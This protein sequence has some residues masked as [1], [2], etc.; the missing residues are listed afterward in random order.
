MT[1]SVDLLDRQIV[2]LVEHG[3]A[4][5]ERHVPVE[6]A[7]LLVAGRQD[8]VLRRN[9]VD[10]VL[11]RDA[12]RL[13]RLLIEIDLHLQ[14]LAAIGRRHRGAL[15]GGELRP[16]EVLSEVEQLHLRQ[17]AARQRELEDRHAGGVVAQDIGR[18]DAGRQQFQHGLRGRRHLRHG[19]GDIDFLLEEDL[20]H[21]ITVER[22]RLDVFDV[23]D[24]GGQKALVIIDDA[25]GHVVRQQAV[26][27]PDDA[28]DRDVDVRKDVGRRRSAQRECRIAR[29]SSERTT[30]V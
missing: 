4:G 25:A 19:G 12:V 2:D 3:R 6:L 1:V 29:S 30:N 13:H 28:D 24:L 8:Q 9:R 16:D 20:D 11:R 18:R 14:D 21:A 22:L 17:G 15:D 26:I 10:D 23:A 5:V 27:G 7:D